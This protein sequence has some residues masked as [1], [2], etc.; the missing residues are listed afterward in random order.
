MT[1]NRSYT[2]NTACVS[3]PRADAAFSCAHFSV[4]SILDANVVA[5]ILFICGIFILLRVSLLHILVF[6]GV[7]LVTN[8]LIIRRKQTFTRHSV[9]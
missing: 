3:A 4:L 1:F 8:K 5:S 6:L 9:T 2:A 7:L